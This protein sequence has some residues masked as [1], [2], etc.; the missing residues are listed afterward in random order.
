MLRAVL[1]R[2]VANNGTWS[3]NH[4]NDPFD[5]RWAAWGAAVETLQIDLVA[6]GWMNM[7]SALLE[8]HP[9]SELRRLGIGP[10]SNAEI[11][12]A[13]SALFGRFFGRAALRRHHGCRW[14]RQVCDGIEVAPGIRLQRRPGNGGDL[15]DWVG[16]DD[17]NDCLVVAEA[18][19]SYD[20]GNWHSTQPS[21]PRR[22]LKQLEG[23]EIVDV[24]GPVQFKTWAVACRW[25]TIANAVTPTII[26]CDPNR[27]GRALNTQEVDALRKESRA[28]WIADLLQGIGR[29]DIATVVRLPELASES[30]ASS[31]DLTLIPGRLGYGALAIEAGGILPLIGAD[32]AGRARNI[33][34][35]ARGLQ[36]E[37]ALV[38]V[39]KDAAEGAILRAG[40]ARQPVEEEKMTGEKGEITVDGVTFRTIVDDIGQIG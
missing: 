26:C 40:P 37:T 16:W 15:P 20:I 31:R 19:G 12:R 2:E 21:P 30:P 22:A 3:L 8:P 35:I 33:I 29:P 5:L 39:A 36:R 6:A 11:K 1:R 9:S 28:R 18:K 10:G 23:V 25:G 38:L 34:E 7:F 13:S 27:E 14:L 4:W 32:R 17:A 24:T